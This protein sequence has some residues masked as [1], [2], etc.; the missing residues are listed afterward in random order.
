MG[1]RDVRCRYILDTNVIAPF[2]S[3]HAAILGG[4]W[5]RVAT[6]EVN[7]TAP[8]QLLYLSWLWEGLLLQPRP[9]DVEPHH[10]HLLLPL[11]WRWRR[12]G[13]LL[14]PLP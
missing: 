4:C 9:N 13:L 14:Q 12:V 2:Y 7:C 1:Q 11:P 10:R 6:M 3:H 8:P 5:A